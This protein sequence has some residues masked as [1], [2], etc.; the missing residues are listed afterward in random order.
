MKL[1]A[2][3]SSTLLLLF[4]FSACT[5]APMVTPPEEPQ[6]TEVTPPLDVPASI[7]VE[8]YPTPGE[9]RTGY[10]RG[11]SGDPMEVTY[12]VHD[13]LAIW[14]GDIILGAADEIPTSMD[15]LLTMAYGVT[16]DGSEYR[17][18][19]GVVPYTYT[20]GF[21]DQGRV[22]EAMDWIEDQ[23]PGVR[24]VYKDGHDDYLKFVDGSGC[25]SFVGL[26]G[27]AQDVVLNI[28]C[29]VGNAAH[30]MLHALG[31]YHE[32]SRCDR[33]SFVSVQWGNIHEDDEHNFE[34][35]CEDA[36]DHFAYDY[37]SMMHLSL[38]HI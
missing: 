14:Q 17:W 9:I 37:G 1:S 35:E 19:G 11:W 7:H 31:M 20:V 27:G 5:D 13:G 10:I 23:T 16:I 24:F 29:G 32:H 3:L 38:I 22:E 28:A 8:G 30:E 2:V 36:T 34:K 18:P 15:E 26:Q 4:A 6:A 33:D 21:Q 25:S 12:E